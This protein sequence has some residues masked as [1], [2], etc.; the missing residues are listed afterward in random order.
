M[1]NEERKKAS[2]FAFT[3]SDCCQCLLI[4]EEE[5]TVTVVVVAAAPGTGFYA[6]AAVSL[7]NPD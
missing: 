3:L 7:C 6:H 2:C 4:E 1:V 5:D